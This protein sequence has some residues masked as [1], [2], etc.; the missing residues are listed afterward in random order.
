MKSSFLPNVNTARGA[1]TWAIAATALLIIVFQLLIGTPVVPL[2]I[3]TVILLAVL[4]VML[5]R[6]RWAPI[7][8]VLLGIFIWA[9]IIG[10]PYGKDH[11]T[12]ADQ[13]PVFVGFMLLL[14][15]MAISILGSAVALFETSRGLSRPLTGWLRYTFTGI[16][17]VIVGLAIASAIVI[18]NPS[19]PVSVPAGTAHLTATAFSPTSVTVTKGSSL[20]LIADTGVTHILQNG[21][22]N[23]QKADSAAEPGA[24]TVNHITISG[25]SM[26]I[27]PFT[28]SGTYHIYCIVHP[29]MMLTVTVP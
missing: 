6:W 5:T 20:H 26:A 7:F 11:L 23:G 13:G 25:G 17:G 2:I 3:I 16:G 12:H 21:S 19:A 1:A 4:S 10:N 27:G 18:A 28:T 15:L 14:A 29:G 9:G 24:P 8:G 22:W